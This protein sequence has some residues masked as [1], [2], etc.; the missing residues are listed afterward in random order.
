[1]QY[2]EVTS[3]NAMRAYKDRPLLMIYSEADKSTAS[4]M[5]I[6]ESFAK[7]SAGERRLTVIVAPTEHGTKMLRGPV[8]GQVFDWIERPIKP[9]VA[10]STNSFEDESGAEPPPPSQ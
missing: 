7:M 10:A 3:V 1:M 2:Q 6:L 8:I 5:P 9:E 4:G